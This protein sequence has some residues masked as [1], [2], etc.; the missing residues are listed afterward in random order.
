[1]EHD[2]AEWN[3]IYISLY[4]LVILLKIFHSITYTKNWMEQKVEIWMELD[5]MDFIM[6]HSFHLIHYL[7]IQTMESH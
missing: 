1:M 3:E 6:F 5:G 7:Q 4:C 2:G